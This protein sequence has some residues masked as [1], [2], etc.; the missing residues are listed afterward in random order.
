MAGAFV[1]PE[2]IRLWCDWLMYEN[3]SVVSATVLPVLFL[4][5]SLLVT[6]QFSRFRSRFGL[7]FYRIFGYLLVLVL[8][9]S[10]GV[11]IRCAAAMVWDVPLSE[12]WRISTAICI[13]M[14]AGLNLLGVIFQAL[15]AIA[16]YR[17]EDPADDEGA[18][19]EAASSPRH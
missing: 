14:L 11:F 1:I 3:F 18:E 5:S 8:V 19:R 12:G 13:S 10:G 17:L 4:S 16:A 9:W 15:M 2:T 6:L 7:W